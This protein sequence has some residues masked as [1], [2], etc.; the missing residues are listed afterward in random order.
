[1]KSLAA[2]LIAWAAFGFEA[3]A[4]EAW[5]LNR[6]LDFAL[7]NSPDARLAVQRMRVAQA[8]VEQ[9]NSAFW[10]QLSFLSGYTRTDN[11]MLSFGHI[12]NQQRYSQAIN[13]NDVPDT[14][15]LNVRGL[16]TVPLYAGGKSRA[17][18]RAAEAGSQAAL[19]EAE[20]VRLALAG[21]VARTFFTVQKTRQFIAAAE[22]AVA[23][24]ESSLGVARQRFDA[25]AALR[26]DVLDLEVRLAQAREDL[27][28]ARN[29]RALAQRALQHLLGLESGEF[30]VSEQSPT[31]ALPPDEIE[32][33]R[34]EFAAA[35]QRSRAAES[36]VSSARSGYRPRVSAFGTVDWDN[37]WETGGDGASYTAGVLLQWDLWDG[38][39]TRGRVNEARARLEAALEEERKMRLAVSFE[40]EQARLDLRQAQE[41]LHV[42][43]KAV[44]QAEESLA[45]TRDRFT[46][47]AALATQLIDAQTALTA[48]RV[49]H[50]D[51]GADVQIATAALRKALGLPIL[52]SLTAPQSSP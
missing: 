6:A 20:A 30:E 2:G 22:A 15:N 21:E 35:A 27:V 31:L 5:T 36:Q 29:A 4:A 44:A 13:F 46:Q 11:P 28:R 48:A 33:S 26:A 51:A 8:G 16:L 19:Q 3:R 42:G 9:A 24:Y 40:V 47:G 10:P 14:D 41:R 23:S 37:G 50:A 1:M 7:T 18:R 17:D 49:R 52:E 39:L 43:E 38:R 32:A 25:G 45:I 34:P 12:L